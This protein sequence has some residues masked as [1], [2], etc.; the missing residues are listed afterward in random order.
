MEK[1]IFETHAHYDD[2]V[3]DNDR[4]ALLNSF[5]VNNIGYVINSGASLRGSKATV[6]LCSQYDF[7]YG[8]IGLHPDEIGDLSDDVLDYFRDQIRNNKKIVAV[9]EIGLDYHWDVHPRDAQKAG[10]IRQLDL[11]ISENKPVIIHSRDACEDTLSIM[12]EYAKSGLTG[13]MH[14]FSYSLMV[15]REYVKMGFMLGIG[16]VVTFKNAR[17]LKEVVKEIPLTNLILETDCPY[18]APEPYRGSRNSS[19][20]LEYVAKAIADI[21][22]ISYEEVLMAT[23]ENAKRIYLSRRR[24]LPLN[25]V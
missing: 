13:T 24:P 14:C 20:N 3:F 18:L 17:V 2:E 25:Q 6:D 19:L 22:E 11:A 12:R 5:P 16:G 4:E 23:C 10:F 7:M 1:L 8:S 9:G 15:A 21:K